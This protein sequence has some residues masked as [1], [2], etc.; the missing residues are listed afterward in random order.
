MKIVLVE[1]YQYRLVSCTSVNVSFP[2][3]YKQAFGTNSWFR[4]SCVHHD[5]DRWGANC[6][7]FRFECGYSMT[8]HYRLLWANSF[9]STVISILYCI[10]HDFTPSPLHTICDNVDWKKIHGWW[11]A[12]NMYPYLKWFL[13]NQGVT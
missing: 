13:H 12:I 3:I 2:S 6:S 4:A 10:E 1:T 8:H 9:S 7:K 5:C 11:L